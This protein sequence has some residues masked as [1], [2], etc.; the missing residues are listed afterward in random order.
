MVETSTSWV[1]NA[2]SVVED[3][4]EGVLLGLSQALLQR[5]DG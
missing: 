2:L 4:T 1:M 5:V 3:G